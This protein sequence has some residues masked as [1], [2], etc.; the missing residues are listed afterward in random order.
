PAAKFD[1]GGL[2]QPGATMAVNATGKP[3]RVLSADHTAKLDA[4]LGGAGVTI[5]AINVNGTFDFSSPSSRKAAANAMVA[6]MKE[7]LRHYDRGRA[8]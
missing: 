2:L 5:Q 4:L 8:R 7:A 6:E 3:E 1:S